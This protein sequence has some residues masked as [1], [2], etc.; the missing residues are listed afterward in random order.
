MIIIYECGQF[1]VVAHVQTGSGSS[2]IVPRS[3]QKPKFQST[4]CEQ[5]SPKL[6][7]LMVELNFL[8]KK[9]YL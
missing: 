2:V 4:R 1:K 3:E 8:I 9:S 5:I 6:R 7:V